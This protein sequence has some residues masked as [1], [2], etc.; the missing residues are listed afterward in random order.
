MIEMIGPVSYALAQRLQ[1]IPE[2]VIRAARIVSQWVQ[3]KVP[4]LHDVRIYGVG[5]RCFLSVTEMLQTL[6]T[7]EAVAELS[8]RPIQTYA[9]V[10]CG[11]ELTPANHKAHRCEQREKG[12]E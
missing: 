10:F 6:E 2:E 7:G 5:T 3:E 8:R 9:C 4:D 11:F 12:S 1:D